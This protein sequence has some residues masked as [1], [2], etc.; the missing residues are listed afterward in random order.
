MALAEKGDRVLLVVVSREHDDAGLGMPLADRVRAV[1]PL[2]LERRRH[3]DVGHHD[4]GGVLGSRG[5]QGR[6]VLGDADDL[7]V[8]VG[9]QQGP[10]A[11]AHEHVVFAEHHPDRHATAP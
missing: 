2:E 11:F 6:R 9:V 3:L 5:E 8:L 7:D 4:V 10:H 1:D